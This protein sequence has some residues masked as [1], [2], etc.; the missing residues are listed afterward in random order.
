MLVID[1]VPAFVCTQ[2]GQRYYE[3]SVAKKMRTLASKRSRL[4]ER[5]SFPRVNF[6]KVGVSA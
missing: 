2:C 6:N 3:A 5:I 4:K 1:D